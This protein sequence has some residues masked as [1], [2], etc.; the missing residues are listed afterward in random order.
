[1]LGMMPQLVFVERYQSIVST[2]TIA[3]NVSAANYECFVGLTEEEHVSGDWE[4][5]VIQN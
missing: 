1:M 4:T 5:T 3:A 2:E